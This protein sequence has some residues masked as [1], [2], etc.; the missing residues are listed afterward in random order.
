MFN[1]IRSVWSVPGAIAFISA[2]DPAAWTLYGVIVV[3]IAGVVTTLINRLAENSRAEKLVR[4][5]IEDREAQQMHSEDTQQKSDALHRAIALGA[6]RADA[7]MRERG[8]PAR[9]PLYC[10]RDPRFQDAG[11]IRAVN[12]QSCILGICAECPVHFAPAG[13]EIL[14]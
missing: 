7:S 12:R 9:P 2:T 11:A 10:P 8:L 3:Q 14:N 4:W 5:Q 1:I 13:K 6:D